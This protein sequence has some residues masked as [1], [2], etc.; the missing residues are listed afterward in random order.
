M[1]PSAPSGDDKGSDGA[2]DSDDPARTNASSD[3]KS[4]GGDDISGS[5]VDA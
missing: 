1:V 2:V 5:A 4:V 3:G